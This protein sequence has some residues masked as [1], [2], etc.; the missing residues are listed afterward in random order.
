MNGAARLAVVGSINIDIAVRMARLPQPGETLNGDSFALSLG[1][2]GANQAVAAC[3]LGADITF[4][5]R[6]GRDGF[7]EIAASRLAAFDLD[8]AHVTPTDAAGTGIATIGIDRE[9]QNAIVVVAGANGLV[10]PDDVAAAESQLAG[11][12][13]LLLQCETPASASIAAARIV[14]AGGG[15][16]ILDPAPV[17]VNGLDSALI[18]LVDVVTPNES[19]AEA[20][21]GIAVCDR[22]SGLAAARALREMGF[23]AAIVKLGGKGVVYHSGAQTGFLPPFAVKVVDTVAAGDSF[24]AGLGVALGEGQG[25]GAALRFASACGALAVTRA[26][27]S[28]AAPSRREVDDFLAAHG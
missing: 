8:L 12:R 25:I 16:V 7:G 27:A 15:R 19:E 2:K 10:S 21:T 14:R 18:R 22:E 17:P 6:I 5:S 20:L 26:G 11:A 28:D 4:V 13:T 1:G 24:N 9:G 3:K 23:P